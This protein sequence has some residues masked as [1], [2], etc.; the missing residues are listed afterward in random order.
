MKKEDIEKF[1]GKNIK[2]ILKNQFI[3]NCKI[4]EINDDSVGILDKFNNL[5][6]INYDMIGAI[7]ENEKTKFRNRNK[8]Y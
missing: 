2:I 7:T 6:F 4:Q 3:Y 8:T 1:R 5:V